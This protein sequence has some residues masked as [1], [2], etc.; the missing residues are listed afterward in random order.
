MSVP[1]GD[2]VLGRDH[3]RAGPEQL[4]Q[5]RGDGFDLVRLE[6]QDHDILCAG[7]TQAA[8]GLDVARHMFGSVFLDQLQSVLADRLE[9]RTARDQGNVFTRECELGAHQ[10]ADGAG[11]DDTDLHGS[12]LQ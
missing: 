3:N 4:G 8:R 1:P 12:T 11:A 10:A 6:G 5:L 2:A 9:M 7:L